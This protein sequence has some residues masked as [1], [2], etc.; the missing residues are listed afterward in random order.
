MRQIALDSISDAKERATLEARGILKPGSDEIQDSS[1]A[2]TA[3]SATPQQVDT[4]GQQ[5][6]QQQQPWGE[7][8]SM[9]IIRSRSTLHGCSAETCSAAHERFEEEC[10]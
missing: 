5:Q 4:V 10:Y 2:A 3:S 7:L 9:I 8:V 1:G 6:Q